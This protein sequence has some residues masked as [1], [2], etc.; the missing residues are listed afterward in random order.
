MGTADFELVAASLRADLTDVRAFVEALAEKLEGALPGA[1]RVSRRGGGLFGGRKRV[2][3]ISVAVGPDQFELEN[4]DGRVACRRRTV[5]RGIALKNEE[6]P[7]EE[8]I[9]AVSR[10]LVTEAEES[11][12]GRTALAR[13]LEA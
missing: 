8:W 1:T 7:L 2:A 10:A 6:L 4:D 9:D 13:L 12:R 5:V 11:E 3:A